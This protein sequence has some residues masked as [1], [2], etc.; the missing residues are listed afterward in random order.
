M[1]A[2]Y[3]VGERGRAEVGVG[4]GVARAGYW[5]YARGLFAGI[6]ESGRSVV[7]GIMESGRVGE[8]DRDVRR[9]E[10]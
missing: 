8:L 5:E 3:G 4:S 2:A 1:R 9:T 10:E 7:T 6:M